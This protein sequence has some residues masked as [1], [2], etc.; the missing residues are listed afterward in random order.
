MTPLGQIDRQPIL[1]RNVI[2]DTSGLV[3]LPAQERDIAESS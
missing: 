3:D 2:A 1:K